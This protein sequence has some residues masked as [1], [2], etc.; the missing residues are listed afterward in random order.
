[1]K[2]PPQTLPAQVQLYDLHG[3]LLM[4]STLNSPAHSLDLSPLT[5]GIYLLRALMLNGKVEV[6][7]IFKVEVR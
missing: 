2:A 3:R 6:H 7:K 5:P 4:Q 1:M